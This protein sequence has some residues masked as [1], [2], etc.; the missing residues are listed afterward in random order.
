MD[1]GDMAIS[2]YLY[3]RFAE[4]QDS[5]REF[6]SF[7]QGIL[8]GGEYD[9]ILQFAN[10]QWAPGAYHPVEYADGSLS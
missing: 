6:G 2:V 9:S 4:I 7:R 5:R 10:T 8:T 1:E 3:Q